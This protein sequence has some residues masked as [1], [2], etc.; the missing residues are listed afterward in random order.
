MESP[1]SRLQSWYR[2]QCDGD[3]EHQHGIEIGTLD[4][5]GW[6]V[7]IDLAH[8]SAATQPFEGVDIARSDCD[9]IRCRVENGKFLGFGGPENLSEIIDIF[10]RWV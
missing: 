3:W 1:L 9:W 2:Q 6:S 7:R 4:N 10:L 5:P 8:A